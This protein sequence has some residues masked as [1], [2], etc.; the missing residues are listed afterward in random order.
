MTIT[1]GA[2]ILAADVYP[3]VKGGI[4]GG[5][6]TLATGEPDILTDQ[7]D[8][9]TLYYTPYLS[10]MISLFDGSAWNIFTFSELSLALTGLTVGK[11]YDIFIYNNSG[12]LTLEPLVW[13]NDTTRATALTRQNGILVKTG[14]LTRRYLGTV[15]IDAAGAYTQDQAT[16][17]YVWN[18]YNRVL[19][20]I[21]QRANITKSRYFVIGNPAGQYVRFGAGGSFNGTASAM[22]Y[23]RSTVEPQGTPPYSSEAGTQHAD[24]NVHGVSQVEVGAFSAGLNYI[25]M[26]KAG[27]GT[28]SYGH[29]WAEVWC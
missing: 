27:A 14:A 28:L 21:F 18:M 25:G 23:L 13:T 15:Y 16:T 24:S 11:P 17:R 9:T 8:K 26:E 22:L 10:D 7:I 12:T 5:R 19:K 6:L 20:Y 2:Q 3:L 4:P 29:V 1:S